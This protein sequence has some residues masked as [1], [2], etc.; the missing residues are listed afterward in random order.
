MYSIPISQKKQGDPT[1]A[2][3]PGPTRDRHTHCRRADRRR[4]TPDQKAQF[5]RDGYLVLRGLLT[6]AEVSAIRDAFMEANAAGPVPGLS[7]IG[8]G[9]IDPATRSPSTRA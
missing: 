1:H 6:P 5:D 3:S 7:A 8:E 4:L 9:I 2:R